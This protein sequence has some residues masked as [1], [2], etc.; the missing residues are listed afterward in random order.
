MEQI[1]NKVTQMHAS[2]LLRVLQKQILIGNHPLSKMLRPQDCRIC[3]T[4]VEGGS[5]VDEYA[6]KSEYLRID[7]QGSSKARRGAGLPTL[8]PLRLLV[9]PI[10]G[11]V[12]LQ[13]SPGDATG[14]ERTDVDQAG[15]S[16]SS[17]PSFRISSLAAQLHVG[18]LED[19][20]ER[21]NSSIDLLPDVLYRLEIFARVE[22]W[23]RKAAYLGL[24]TVRKLNFKPQE[25]A[26]FGP[27]ISTCG[28]PVLYVPLGPRFQAFYLALQPS[29]ATGVNV[30]LISATQMIDGPVVAA[31]VLQSIEWLDRIRIAETTREALSAREERLGKRKRNEAKSISTAAAPGRGDL[32]LD[33][34][35]SLHTYSVAL[36]SYSRVEQQLRARGIP[37]MHV[38]NLTSRPGAPIQ[39]TGDE[40]KPARK[41]RA[42]DITL[43]ESEAD[44]E[45]GT[46]RL[47]P[48][49][50]LRATDLL[51]FGRA[52]LVKRNVSVSVRDWWHKDR[53]RVEIR[54]KLRMKSRRLQSF[55]KAG[56][57]TNATG[58][59][60]LDFDGPNAVLTYSSSDLDNC[61]VGFLAEWERVSKAVELAREVLNVGRAQPGPRTLALQDFN[62]ESVT[63]SY[64]TNGAG[65]TLLARVRWLG[66]ACQ[67]DFGVDAP[68]PFG[69]SAI[70]AN[71]HNAMSF[72]LRRTLNASCVWRGFFQL[73]RD[74]YP[75]I[76]LL[77]PF[78]KL[79]L[80]DANTPELEVRSATW[81]RLRIRDVHALDIRL[82]TSSRYLI[83]DAAEP[84]FRSPTK[85]PESSR[86]TCAGQFTP[87]DQFASLIPK[88]QTGVL[89]LRR[90][91]LCDAD[92]IA[93]LLP[94]L[95]DALRQ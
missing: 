41:R 68:D 40:A 20:S 87:I 26:K 59:S 11:K 51:G 8:P 64:A 75:L 77:A 14:D 43:D 23:E 45:A 9:D 72:E 19:A 24:R 44:V 57:V 42:G 88:G 76:A 84:L 86:S 28:P 25:Y 79:S 1:L 60:W 29:E 67:V 80:T 35:A 90:A 48:T 38:G 85:G 13:V 5:L 27:S 55:R 53:I 89:D 36:V 31:M 12:K 34:L 46:S 4:P 83:C 94:T 6:H 30:A 10:S 61:V 69:A 91:M 62:L 56:S 66:P 18:R 33:E 22:E 15:G 78:V 63:F 32:T 93:T 65:Q 81:F 17:V 71:A 73:L 16:L 37:Y 92:K 52:N 95:L 54:I 49:I 47:V 58:E 74:T 2:A 70:E 7:L 3:S 50:C 82:V 39:D 21:V